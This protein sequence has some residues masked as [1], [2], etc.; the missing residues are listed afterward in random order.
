MLDSDIAMWQI[1]CTTSCGIVVSLSVGGVVQHVRIAGIRVVEFGTKY[2]PCPGKKSLWFT[3][4]NCN[5]FEYIFT[6]FGTNH[7]DCSFY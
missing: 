1:C 6:V 5:K 4:H 3:M 7:R 2:T